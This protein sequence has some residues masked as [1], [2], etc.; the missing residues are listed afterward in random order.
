MFL[1]SHLSE[2]LTGAKLTEL[3]PCVHLSLH[4]TLLSVSF[5]K[6]ATSV[7]FNYSVKPELGFAFVAI[8]LFFMFK[9][10][11]AL[12][13]SLVSGALLIVPA[14][15]HLRWPTWK[16]PLGDIQKYKQRATPR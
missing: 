8:V 14:I 5:L 1:Q 9:T 12:Q 10:H 2:K 3:N 13:R 4:S 6:V 7:Q 11:E 15:T 16:T